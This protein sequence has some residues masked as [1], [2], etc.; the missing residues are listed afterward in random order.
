MGCRDFEPGIE[1]FCDN[2]NDFV[3]PGQI[4]Q[5]AK[6]FGLKGTEMKKVK[7]IAAREAENRTKAPTVETNAHTDS[8][9]V[10]ES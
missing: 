4:I 5:M 2:P 7:L 10:G 1:K 9:A 8:L 6:F 3:N